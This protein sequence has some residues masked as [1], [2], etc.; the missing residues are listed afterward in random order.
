VWISGH[1]PSLA[2]AALPLLLLL[3]FM[4]IVAFTLPLAFIM[5]YFPDARVT[6]DAILRSV[7]LISGI[8]FP[9]DRLPEVYRL[10]FHLNPLADLI[11][12][13]RAVLI[14]GQWPRWD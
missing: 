9:V 4:T 7:M 14:N 3:E 13:Y 5:P 10:Y 12:A 11:E 1:P 2:Y 6:V 8:F